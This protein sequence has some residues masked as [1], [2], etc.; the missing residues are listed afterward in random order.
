[1]FTAPFITVPN[2]ILVRNDRSGELRE[3]NLSGLTVS[4]VS[5]YAITEY[6]TSKPLGLQP[7]LVADDLTALLNAS[8]GR[9]DAA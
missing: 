3:E 5:N 4:L 1:N 9:S 8:F 7:D 2:V 6:L